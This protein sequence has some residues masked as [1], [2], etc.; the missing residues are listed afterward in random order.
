MINHEPNLLKFSIGSDRHL[1]VDCQ[2][3]FGNNVTMMPPVHQISGFH[4]RRIP[5]LY[6]RYR[7]TAEHGKFLDPSRKKHAIAVVRQK[8]FSNW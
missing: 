1:L 5:N 3:F 8:A 2:P 7:G 6:A 4:C